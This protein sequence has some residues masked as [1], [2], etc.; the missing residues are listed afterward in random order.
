VAGDATDGP[1]IADAERSSRVTIA[2]AEYNSLRQESLQAIGNR[3]QVLNF[4]FA[5][6]SVVVAAVLAGK[7]PPL[8]AAAVTIAFV[9]SVAK[10]ALLVWLG[11]YSRSQRAGRWIAELETRINAD[12]G[13]SVLGWESRLLTRSAHMGFPYLAVVGLL[14]GTGYASYVLGAHFLTTYFGA[15]HDHLGWGLWGAAAVAVVGAE[16]G[17]LVWVRGAWGTARMG[18]PEERSDG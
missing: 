5:A 6:L 13:S 7:V 1:Q 3:L 9:P 15:H 4:T 16:S 8:A 14:L 12:I 17:F 10:A 2:L 11:E 18:P